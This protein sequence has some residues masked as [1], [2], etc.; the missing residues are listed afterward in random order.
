M[1]FAATTI[2]RDLRQQPA[3]CP[4]YAM[5]GCGGSG[6][7]KNET[8]F[9]SFRRRNATK[10]SL[11]LLTAT[12]EGLHSDD[13]RPGYPTGDPRT[14]HQDEGTMKK[15]TRRRSIRGLPKGSLSYFRLGIYRGTLLYDMVGPVWFC[16]VLWPRSES[17]VSAIK[18]MDFRRV[19]SRR[20]R[21][22]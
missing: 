14:Q 3:C 20:N 11:D 18:A 12:T 15:K 21:P 19:P 7:C 2:A 13:V 4:G 8:D 9:L 17:P 10:C 1:A 22:Q 16:L 6:R 5:A